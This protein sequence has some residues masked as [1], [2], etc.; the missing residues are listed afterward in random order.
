M[1]TSEPTASVNSREW[2]HA[3]EVV[4]SLVTPDW[5]DNRA[6]AQRIPLPSVIAGRRCLDVGTFDGFWAP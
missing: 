6:V 1:S 2:Y 4:P 3:V 5:S